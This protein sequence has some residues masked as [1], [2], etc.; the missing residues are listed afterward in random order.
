MMSKV[1]VLQQL[2]EGIA[3]ADSKTIHLLELTNPYKKWNDLTFNKT[4]RPG[5]RMFWVQGIPVA[6]IPIKSFKKRYKYYT[7]NAIWQ[8][9]TGCRETILNPV[10]DL[11]TNGRIYLIPSSMQEEEDLNTMLA[12]YKDSISN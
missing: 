3:M 7:N 5:H 9:V 8:D 11:I 12:V 2:I 10:N 6:V 4:T 1:L